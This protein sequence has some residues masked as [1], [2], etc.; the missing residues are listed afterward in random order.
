MALVIKEEKVRGSYP[1]KVMKN[2]RKVESWRK[3]LHPSSYDAHDFSKEE[4]QNFLLLLCLRQCVYVFVRTKICS[5]TRLMRCDNGG[6]LNLK[7]KKKKK[8]KKKRECWLLGEERQEEMIWGGRSDIFQNES[9]WERGCGCGLLREVW[10][11]Y[12]HF[13]ILIVEVKWIISVRELVN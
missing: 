10:I 4:R 13:Y 12:F 5:L 6:F 8:M 9:E 3:N 2:A 7:G 11:G 1:L